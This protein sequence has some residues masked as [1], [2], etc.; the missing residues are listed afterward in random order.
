VILPWAWKSLST[1]GMGTDSPCLSPE[2]DV[3][4]A[5]LPLT[6]LEGFLSFP[7]SPGCWRTAPLLHALSW[8]VEEKKGFQ[9]WPG[10]VRPL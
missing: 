6:W 10:A 7:P 4:F 1:K 9:G 8:R 2:N 5:V 3:I